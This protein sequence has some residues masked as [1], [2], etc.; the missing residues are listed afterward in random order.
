FIAGHAATDVGTQANPGLFA[1][2]T[3]HDQA[4]PAYYAA[5]ALL[6]P[7][8]T[9]WFGPHWIGEGLAQFASLLWTERTAGRAAALSQLQDDARLLALAEPEVPVFPNGPAATGTLPQSSSSSNPDSPDHP[10][11]TV[12]AA[13]ASLADATGDVFYRTKAA[14]VWWMLR[15]IV[16]DNTLKQ[17]LQAYRNNPKLDRDPTGFEHT[18]EQISHQD[19]RWFFDNWVYQDRGLPDLSIVNLPPSQ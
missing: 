10:P 15:G 2:V 17:S 16:G 3:A 8:L 6:E 4:L 7:L 11:P 1:A 12:S 19:L 14:A 18:L 13:G 9:D 5:A